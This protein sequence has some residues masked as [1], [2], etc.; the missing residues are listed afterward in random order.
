MDNSYKHF[1][2]RK[3]TK[4][5]TERNPSPPTRTCSG[6][7]DARE[8]HTVA[9]NATASKHGRILTAMASNS[10]APVS[11]RHFVVVWLV[12]R[13]VAQLRL[14]VVTTRCHRG[15]AS[16]MAVRVR[17]S[18]CAARGRGFDLIDWPYHR[19]HRPRPAC[20]A[21]KPLP[22]TAAASSVRRRSRV[23]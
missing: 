22:R 16:P 14:S 3:T 18:C 1:L 21:A 9:K 17:R 20:S 15:D 2:N 8:T 6:T 10:G 23:G 11:T 5:P 7:E 4:Y 19:P 13:G 12:G